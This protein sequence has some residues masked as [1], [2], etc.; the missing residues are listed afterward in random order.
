VKVNDFIDDI[1]DVL[2]EDFVRSPL[3]TRTQLLGYVRQM[4]YEMS[5][6]TMLV[7]R[8]RINLVDGSTGE[9]TAPSD[10]QSGYYLQ[11]NRAMVDLVKYGDLE[12]SSQTW[13]LNGTGATPT[14]ATVF[15]GGETATIRMVPVPSTVTG[16]FASGTV[17][18]LTLAD[19][20]GTVW[21]VTCNGGRLVTTVGGSSGLS[22][23]LRGATTQ[24]TLGIDTLGQLVT[25]VNVGGTVSTVYLTDTSTSEPMDVYTNDSGE[26]VTKT[27][28]YGIITQLLL[29]TT[30]QT[31][32]TGTNST[33][34]EYGVVVDLY[35]TGVSTTPEHVARL[36]GPVGEIVVT[37]TSDYSAELW[38][39]AH[40]VDVL[41]VESELW[42][43]TPFL[44]ML[45]HG[46]LSL[47]FAHNGDGQ[48][49]MK[50]NLLRKLF[51][52]ECEAIKR[53]FNKV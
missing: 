26:I 23:V 52:S 47:A 41:T 9:F 13:A 51:D 28:A 12:Y 27:L 14:A 19:S 6:R 2:Q 17:S 38:Y 8:T 21:T 44:A 33:S 46:V 40:M 18:T 3:W 20:G 39:K 7:D 16:A 42:L 43:S 53:M 50:A 34:A 10:F 36:D 37:R 11:F 29:G 45:K 5:V 30:A 49:M 32:T 25:T 35:A 22:I 31:L 4:L 1:G 15:G 24:W 48:D